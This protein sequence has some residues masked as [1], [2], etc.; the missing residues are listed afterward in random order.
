[1]AWRWFRRG[2]RTPQQAGERRTRRGYVLG[3]SEQEIS[4]LDMQHY[5]FRWE[6][7]GDYLAPVQP[8]AI[9]DV[10]CGTG[11]WAIDMAR[12]FPRAAVAAFDNNP[13]LIARA[14]S[15]PELPGNCTFVVADA[16]KPFEFADGSFD[17]VMARANSSYLAIPQWPGMVA[18]MARVT[19]PGGWVEL[20]DFGLA[21]SESPALMS[22]TE[23]FAQ[24]VA[25]RPMYPGAGPHLADL[26]RAA[27]LRD[28]RARSVVVRMGR[29]PTRGGRLMVTDYL[30]MLDRLTPL[31]AQ[32][33]LATQPQ[34]EGWL[35][36][37]RQ[38][39]A[40]ATTRVHLTAAYGRR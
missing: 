13:D 18:E 3:D 30:S 17:L 29:R 39:T 22:L 24:M 26:L 37:A 12:Q 19:A 33:G 2:P 40:T 35:A 28:I 8:R 38:E 4:R 21:Q 7:G 27:G 6:F 31:M 14:L 15:D 1:M 23:R 36:Q 16:L 25:R 5:M 10:A 34:W 9:L 11:R 32:L 20:R